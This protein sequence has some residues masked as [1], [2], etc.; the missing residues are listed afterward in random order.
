MSRVTI[1]LD[2]TEIEIG[3]KHMTLAFLLATMLWTISEKGIYGFL[4]VDGMLYWG[5]WFIISIGTFFA[6][7]VG[8][9]ILMAT[10]IGFLFWCSSVKKRY[11][12]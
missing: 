11:S 8:L 6:F 5:K 9:L 1:K 3:G 12:R 10:I 7:S 2:D 4:S